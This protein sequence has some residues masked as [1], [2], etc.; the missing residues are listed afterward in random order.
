[1]SRVTL[2]EIEERDAL[3][4]T[5]INADLQALTDA[6][7]GAAG[8]G[9]DDTNIAEEGFDERTV[10]VRA[11]T[12]ADGV[13][14][15]S[16]FTG[17]GP[18]TLS[19]NTLQTKAIQPDG[20]NDLVC[21]PFAY[22]QAAGDRIMVRLSLDY[23]GEPYDGAN[24]SIW[25]FQI[26]YSTDYVPGG[27]TWSW[28]SPTIRRLAWCDAT[29]AAVESIKGSL[30]IAHLFKTNVGATSTLYFGVREYQETAASTSDD[31]FVRY[32]SFYGKLRAK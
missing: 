1:M 11:V 17:A 9:I 15:C 16:T 5:P 24:Q 19:Y 7:T 28:L 13:A 2:S 32:I 14:D 8:T 31:I 4:V 25:N 6:S 3:T 29:P 20:A 23:A 18:W 30:T 10:A 26:G 21:G 22:N 12:P 27:G